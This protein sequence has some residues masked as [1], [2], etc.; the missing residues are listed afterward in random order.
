MYR[1]YSIKGSFFYYIIE[2]YFQKFR[3]ICYMGYL[4]LTN[5]IRN[6]NPTN[7]AVKYEHR[8]MI[9]TIFFKQCVLYYSQVPLPIVFKKSTI[10]KRFNKHFYQ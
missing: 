2:V 9:G 1:L 4:L 7:E 6:Q 10:F 8:P 3:I 5:I